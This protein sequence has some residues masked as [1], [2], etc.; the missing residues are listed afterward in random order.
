MSTKMLIN[1]VEAEEARVALVKDG[2][3]ED[4]YIE[5]HGEE[6]KVG[7]IY[8]GVIEKV[9]PS[10]QAC[11]V[12]IGIEKNGFLPFNEIHPEYYLKPFD[13]EKPRPIHT[14]IKEGQEALVQVTKEMPG[15]KGHHLTTYLS[16]ASRFLVLTPG[17]EGGGISKKIADEAERA[18][19]KKIMSQFKFPDGV[20]YIVR[21]AAEGQSK[22]ELSKDLKRLLRVWT[23]IKKRVKTAPPLSLI[24]EEQD[25]CL[26]VLRDHFSAEVSEVLVDDKETYAKVKTYMKVISPRYQG[27]VKLYKDKVPI[28]DRFEVEKQIEAIFSN[29]VE[30]KSGGYITIDPTEALISIDV[31]SGKGM[32]GKD[33]ETMAFRTNLEAAREVARQVRLRDLGGLIVVDFIDMRDKRHIREVEKVLREEFKKDKAKIDMSRISKF[34]LVEI[35]RQRIRPP[36]E[37]RRYHVCQYCHGR[38]LVQS[39]ESAA[40]SVMRRISMALSRGKLVG[41]EGRLPEGVASYLQNKKRRELAELESR[42]NVEITLRGDPSLAP[43]QADLEFI[44][45]EAA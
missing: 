44:K 24:H 31:N 25:V 43:G 38:G 21:T 13:P 7:N 9:E 23:D 8:K 4:F 19:I 34:G 36:I 30:L 29:R 42:Y 1:A 10:L 32:L 14:L 39:V 37:S 22:R 2:V 20:G 17:R 15:R 40:V 5:T 41:V 18:R 3:L 35:S 12:N 33:L 11:F 28:F 26:R 45:Q 16:I 6:E 27:R